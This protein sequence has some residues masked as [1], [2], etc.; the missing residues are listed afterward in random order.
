M[1]LIDKKEYRKRL[2]VFYNKFGNEIAKVQKMPIENKIS[3]GSLLERNAI[4]HAERPALFFEN[5]QFTYK[6]FNEI[7]NQYANYF[8]SIGLKK[9]DVVEILMQNR[10]EL[11]IIY[12]AVAKI[13]ALSS[14]INT[15]L[16][17]K[18]L[19]YCLNLTPGKFVI[20][21]EECYYIFD[22]VKSILNPVEEQKLFFVPDQGIMDVPDGFEDLTKDIKESSVNNPPTTVNVKTMDPIG[23]IF[24]SGTTGLPKAAIL[25][26][27]RMAVYGFYYGIFGANF[28]SNDIIYV[29]LPLFHGTALAVGWASVMA[30][31]GAIALSRKLS[32]SRFWEDIRKYNA[33]AFVYIGELCRYLM[34]QKPRPDDSNNTVKTIIGV[35]LRPEIW[36]DFKKR[37][38]ISRVVESYGA[39]EGNAGFI[40]LLNFDCTV[41]FTVA[42]YAVVEYDIE[43]NEPIRDENGYFKKVSI[44]G[45]GL[46]LIKSYGAYKFIGYTDKKANEK[47]I[48]RNVFVDGDE[49]FNTGDLMREIGYS[50]LQFVDRLGD[51][52]RWKGHN[53]STTEVEEV[54]NTHEDVLF[55][56]VYGVQIPLTD[57]RAGMAAIVPKTSVDEFDFKKLIENFKENLASYAIPIFLR[58]KS[59]IAVTA[60][61]KFKKIKL[62]EKGFDID[63]TNDI[64]YVL[65][66]GE[67]EY[68]LLTREIYNNILN[69]K[70]K[71]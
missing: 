57:G 48:F 59:E 16:K 7:V 55:S 60:T 36:K 21:G 52:F 58:F 47:K 15:K 71:Y 1:H 66:P 43:A 29:C 33:T 26:H 51:T 17:K 41:G 22:E 5:K 27:F 31:G 65:L 49:W 32:V 13:G 30:T 56:C 46:L 10:T 62:K 70:Y 63:K 39:S 9:G 3:W 64:L 61:F 6:Q 8:I 40:N 19:A 25:L 23:Y 68:T 54:I 14:M 38:D 67:S 11:L 2:R 12:T 44:G 4:E 50:H 35:G 20:V 28:T 45:T 24:T 34:N 37:F 42:Q 18:T 53:V 69:H